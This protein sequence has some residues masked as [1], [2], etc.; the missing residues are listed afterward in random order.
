MTE[1]ISVH[2]ENCGCNMMD[3]DEACVELTRK[4]VRPAPLTAQEHSRRMA[5]IARS[6][7]TS[8]AV[9]ARTDIGEHGELRNV[10]V[11]SWE[12]RIIA[13]LT[14]AFCEGY[15]DATAQAIALVE[16]LRK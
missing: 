10:T 7:T 11:A 14:D 5:S 3:Q 8:M 6:L 13:A 12:A 2:R 15:T 1:K 9:G 4:A 16:S